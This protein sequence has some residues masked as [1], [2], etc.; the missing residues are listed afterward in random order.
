MKLSKLWEEALWEEAY[1]TG[2]KSYWVKLN[3]NSQ[4]KD[5]IYVSDTVLKAIDAGLFA[6]DFVANSLNRYSRKDM[7]IASKTYKKRTCKN[8]ARY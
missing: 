4:Q 2:K 1:P 7:G 3:A 6:E 8:F 5:E